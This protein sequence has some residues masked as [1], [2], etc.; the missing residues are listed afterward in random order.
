MYSNNRE[1]LHNRMAF[2]PILAE[3]SEE[4]AKNWTA[5]D[6]I[7]FFAQERILL[8]AIE[9]VTDIGSLL[10]DA[11]VL[12]DA[13]S[14]EDIIEI[15]MDE[16]VIAGPLALYLPKL[17]KLRK[18]LVQEYTRFSRDALHPLIPELPAMLSAFGDQVRMFITKE[19]AI[20]T[21]PSFP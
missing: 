20:F 13:G 1:E 8:L 3:V 4:L 12:R 18:A 21:S 5:R 2:L 15:L 6:F 17:V 10:I 19:D 11:F 14:Y 7:Q 9:T 16:R